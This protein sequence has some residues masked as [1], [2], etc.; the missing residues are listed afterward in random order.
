MQRMF[1]S[2]GGTVVI[3]GIAA[4][5]A[6]VLLL[7]YLSQYRDNLNNS[8]ESVTVLVANK[9]IPQGTPGDQVA[10]Q[11]WY[12]QVEVQRRDLLDGA[13]TNPSQIAGKVAASSVYP[14]T[15]LTTSQFTSPPNNSA[16]V[17]LSGDQRAIAI[18]FDAAHGAVGYVHPGDHVDILAG[19]NVIPLD[20]NGVP[21]QGAQQRPVMKVIAQDVPVLFVPAAVKD[22]STQA[23]S[24]DNSV[25]VRLTDEQ[26]SAVAFASDNGKVWISVRGNDG[27]SSFDVNNKDNFMTLEQLLFNVKPVAAERSFGAR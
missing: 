18:P 7:V 23:T 5:V 20:K 12:K 21:L 8:N 22:G 24:S 25:V 10:G 17:S 13:I 9:L 19:F 11:H 6:A 14:D 15:Q 16:S 4:L 3:G 2:R 27:T 1:H 26:A